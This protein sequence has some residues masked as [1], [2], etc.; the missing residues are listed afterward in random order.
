MSQYNG[1]KGE[2]PPRR[3]KP[4]LDPVHLTDPNP[5][6]LLPLDLGYTLYFGNPLSFQQKPNFERQESRPFSL[7][8]FLSFVVRRYMRG[9]EKSFIRRRRLLLLLSLSLFLSL[10]HVSKGW[11]SAYS[12]VL[13]T[14]TH[15]QGGILCD[16]TDLPVP[17][18]RKIL[19]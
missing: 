5:V 15:A 3:K 6:V 13:H 16:L 2:S 17:T 14:H 1:S 4:P 9:Y 7:F 8:F 10:I 11:N 12:T 19:V 18:V